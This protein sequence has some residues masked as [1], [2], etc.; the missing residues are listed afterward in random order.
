MTRIQKERSLFWTVIVA[1]YIVGRLM[2]AALH[3]ANP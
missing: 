3:R 1:L 2:I